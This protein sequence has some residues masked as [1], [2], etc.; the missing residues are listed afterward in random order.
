MENLSF[1]NM[2]NPTAGMALAL[3][4]II[5]MMILPVP[6]WVLDIGLT[7]SFAFAILIFMLT[8]FIEKPLDFSSF[9]AVLLATLILRLS[10]NIS[11]TKLIIG[12]GHT[13]TDAAGGI[14]EGFAK[15]IM[16]DNL[17]L[18]LIVFTVLIIVNFMVITKGA[19][20][21]AEVGARFALDAMPGKQ[22]AIDADLAAGAI[23][24]EEASARRK[25]EQEET[26]FLGSLD[27]V[28]KFVKGDA[29]AG[30]LIT[31][32]NLI[33]GIAIGVGVHKVSFSDALA[34]YSLLTVGDGLVSQI[35]AVIISISAALLLAKGKEE[36]T[37]DKTMFKQFTAHPAALFSVALVMVVFALFPGLPFLPF[38]VGAGL[39]GY[40]GLNAMKKQ[41]A[42]AIEAETPELLED[43]K[44]VE[45]TMGD[46]LD[47]D[48]IHLVLSKELVPIA[49]DQE[50]GFNK[51][52]EK[53]RKYIATEFG[54]VL[55][56]V[57]LTDNAQLEADSYKIFIQGTEVSKSIL[58]PDHVM[59]LME[60]TDFPEI[61]GVQ[62]KEPVYNASARWVEKS[63]RDELV[64][65]GLPI[66]EAEEVLATHLLETLQAH[67]T[68]LLTRRSLRETL[69]A[70]KNVTDEARAA[71]N[72]KLLD[73][74]IPDKVPMDTFQGVLRLLL[75]ERVSMRNIPLIL[76]TIA[77]VKPVMNSVE[78]IAECVRQRIS[79]QF[80]AKMRDEKGRLPLVQLGPEWESLFTQYEVKHEGGNVD[81]ALPP[82]EFSRLADAVSEKLNNS[83]SQGT[84]AAIATSARRRRFL[85]TVMAAKGI[86]NPVISYEEIPP[87]ERPVILAVA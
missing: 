47:I 34:N 49:M 9:P 78:Q 38:I 58:K 29:I 42:E 81:I 68:K 55:P 76:E 19:G 60:E 27:G 73:E 63:R 45:E 64:M 53:I 79:Y 77:E 44:P 56:A 61:K 24:H 2:F 1:K 25:M 67:F 10:L 39:L 15:F 30:L 35:P 62:F 66:I 69:D 18:G 84:Y 7:A 52:V 72:T 6:S 70:F 43:V 13:G 46:V 28:S 22:L 12:E 41:A 23:S 11:S 86:R 8:L 31:L 32:L 36:G 85:K 71:S 4:T 26:A 21:M 80:I 16:G 54:F 5:V 87:N 51:R 74:F 57:R 3:I 50:T 40:L 59:A 14:I 37:V 33:A 20:R 82:D 17:F 48:E 65:H 75:S 83:A